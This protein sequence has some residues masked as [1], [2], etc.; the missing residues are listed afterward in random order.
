MIFCGL[1]SPIMPAHSLDARVVQFFDHL[2][3]EGKAPSTGEKLIA[4]L[5]MF[6]PDHHVRGRLPLPRA[7]PN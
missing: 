6:I 1:A 3:L 2:C 4:A 7:A 5:M